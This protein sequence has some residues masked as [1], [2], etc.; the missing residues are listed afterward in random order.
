MQLSVA[1]PRL[2]LLDLGLQCSANASHT[3][4]SCLLAL[5]VYCQY[6]RV[7]WIHFN[8]INLVDDIQFLSE[9]PDLRGLGD[10][11]TRCPLAY[12]GAGCLP[13]PSVTDR[14][15]TAIAKGFMDIFPLI[16]RIGS[17]S[18]PGWSTLDSRVH[19]L[20]AAPA[21]SSVEQEHVSDR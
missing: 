11:P 10:L 3:T 21:S 6:L 13:F 19:Q 7:M 2:E 1:L 20:R 17:T 14:D 16:P 18:D 8:A 9:D 15:V 5:S 12:F 4:V